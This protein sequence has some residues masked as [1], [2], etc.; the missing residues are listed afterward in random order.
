[1]SRPSLAAFAWTNGNRLWLEL[2]SPVEGARSHTVELPNSIDGLRRALNILHARE[3][4]ASASTLATKGAPTQEQLTQDE[5]TA[6]LRARPRRPAKPKPLPLPGL[7][8][9]VRELLRKE[10]LI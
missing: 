4:L 5:A 3:A 2:P 1:M 8:L 10:G 9:K 6:F 7:S